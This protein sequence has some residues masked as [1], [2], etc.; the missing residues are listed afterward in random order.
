MI[1][2]LGGMPE[3][4]FELRDKDGNLKSKSRKIETWYGYTHLIQENAQGKKIVKQ[5]LDWYGR[6]VNYLVWNEKGKKIFHHKFK[7]GKEGEQIE[8]DALNKK[9]FFLDRKIDKK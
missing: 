4:S 9:F 1:Q 3:I 5:T 7:Y 8:F 2:G 6:L